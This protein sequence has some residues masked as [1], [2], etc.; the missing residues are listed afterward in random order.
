[1]GQ[2]HYMGVVF[3]AIG[4]THWTESPCE[5]GTWD[6]AP[7]VESVVE[8]AGGYHRLGYSYESWTHWVG[9]RIADNANAYGPGLLTPDVTPLSDFEA[10]LSS[11]FPGEIKAARDAWE[12]LREAG[13]ANGVDVPE[14]RLLVVFD[15]D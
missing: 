7:W 3:G 11:E 12:R 10:W 9:F 1:M 13:K 4:D 2:G 14:G 8:S 15:Y 5:N 6:R